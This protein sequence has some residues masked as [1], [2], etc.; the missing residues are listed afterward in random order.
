MRRLTY[1]EVRQELK[2]MGVKVV[3]RQYQLLTLEDILG[4]N[5]NEVSL[6]EDLFDLEEYY[7]RNYE[8]EREDGVFV[9]YRNGT[10]SE[11]MSVY[12]IE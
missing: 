10:K 3:S 5:I 7:P 1:E 11:Q 12:I 2:A 4:E 6:L 8:Y 9:A